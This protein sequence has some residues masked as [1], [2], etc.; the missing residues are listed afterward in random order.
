MEKKMKILIV[1]DEPD[2]L[3][4]TE[5]RI[6]KAGFDTITAVNGEEGLEKAEKERPDLILLDYRLPKMNGLDVFKILQ[7]S[8][9][10]R[11]I[12]V[13][14]LTASRGNEDIKN[15]LEESGAGNIMIKPYDPVDLIKKISEALGAEKKGE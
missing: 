13:I 6:R 5:F 14:F 7:S 11:E 4:M 10:L 1:D 15:M 8:D 3:K 2:I 9:E 12:P